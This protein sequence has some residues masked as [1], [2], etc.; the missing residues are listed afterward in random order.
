MY[1]HD[2]NS[3]IR[4]R[5]L[6]DQVIRQDRAAFLPVMDFINIFNILTNIKLLLL[7]N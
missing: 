3:P 6:D 5:S 4:R 7:I 2:P 1:I